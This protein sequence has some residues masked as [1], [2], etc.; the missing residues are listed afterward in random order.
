MTAFM[1]R[2]LGCV[3]NVIAM[4]MILEP[5]QIAPEIVRI[6]FAATVGA[7]A[8]ALALAFGPGGRDVARRIL[9]EAYASGREAKDQADTGAPPPSP[10]I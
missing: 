2:V 7:L 9:E 5:L 10:G 8:L 6:A 4:F 1:D 3:P